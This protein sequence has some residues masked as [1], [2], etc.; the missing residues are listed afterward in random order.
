MTRSIVRPCPADVLKA[1][2][3]LVG[4]VVLLEER[5]HIGDMH[6]PFGRHYLRT[7]CAEGVVHRYRQMAFALI[8][9]TLHLRDAYRGDGD[10][11]G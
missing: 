9:K 1:H 6:E 2:A 10:A 8:E 5:H 4:P 11:L 7:L 3:T